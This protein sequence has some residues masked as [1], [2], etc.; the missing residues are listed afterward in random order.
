MDTPFDQNNATDAARILG[1]HFAT[2][3]TWCRNGVINAENVSDGSQHARWQISDDEV[4][5]ILS[6]K[7]KF[8]SV[9][10]AMLHYKKNW[11]EGKKSAEP[12]RVNIP[13]PIIRDYIPSNKLDKKE[14]SKPKDLVTTIAYMQDVKARI[15]DCKNEL[16]L[17]EK[18]YEDLKK[19]VIDAL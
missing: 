4:N 1:V 13:T 19:E 9:R 16:A 15:A 18:E 3:A 2:V 8:G 11:R 7:E 12:S 14:E 5:Y 6:L 10:E 17:L